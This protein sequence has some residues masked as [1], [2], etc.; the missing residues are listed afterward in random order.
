[1][2]ALMNPQVP[3]DGPPQKKMKVSEDGLTP[4]MMACRHGHKEMVEYLL[5]LMDESTLKTQLH[6]KDL[7]GMDAFAAACVGGHMGILRMLQLLY[8]TDASIDHPNKLRQN[9]LILAVLSG[10]ADAV[11]FLLEE[12]ASWEYSD[13]LDYDILVYATY[14]SQ[15]SILKILRHHCP[16]ILFKRK[17]SLCLELAL[18]DAEVFKYL[19]TECGLV[20]SDYSDA[21]CNS[22][23]HRA[24]N[25]PQVSPDII[26]FI[27]KFIDV[28][29]MD[30]QGRKMA[31]PKTTT[32]L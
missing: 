21:H 11:D 15:I 22:I 25:H 32:F 29:H 27:L 10:N 24:V 17:S 30:Y 7:E 14:F 4:L 5:S 1:M 18:S 2:D 9:A 3:L 13:D 28:N 19:V 12:G 8:P 20:P 26:S 23:L 6:Q 16:L 31:R